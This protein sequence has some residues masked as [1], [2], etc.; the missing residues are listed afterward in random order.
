MKISFKN[1]VFFAVFLIYFIFSAIIFIITYDYNYQ[2]NRKNFMGK[3]GYSTES[4]EDMIEEEKQILIRAARTISSEETMYHALKNGIYVSNSWNLDSKNSKIEIDIKEINRFYFIKLANSVRNRL[5]GTGRGSEEKGIELFN[6]KLELVGVS[7]EFNNKFLDSGN[8]KYLKDAIKAESINGIEI[9]AIQEKNGEYFLKGIAPVGKNSRYFTEKPYGVAVVGEELGGVIA[10]KMKSRINSEIVIIKDGEL[11]L[12]TIFADGIRLKNIKIITNNKIDDGKY[13][14][15]L[16][17]G[18]KYGANF[19]ELRDYQNR[20]IGYIGAAENLVFLDKINRTAISNYLKLQAVTTLVLFIILYFAI[21][22]LFKP[23]REMM[24]SINLIGEGNYEARVVEKGGKEIVEL[25]KSVNLMACEIERRES[26]LKKFNF[27]MEQKVNQR[28]KELVEKNA[29]LYELLNKLKK[30]NSKNEEE[31]EFARRIHEQIVKFDFEKIDSYDIKI[32]NWSIN[33]IGG[34]F[35]E[36][37]KLRNG[38]TGIFFADI[39]GHGVAAALMISAVKI[40]VNLYFVEINKPSEALYFL[41]DMLIRDMIPGVTISAV[42]MVINEK[43]NNLEIAQAAQEYSYYISEN[44]VEKIPGKG[45]ILGVI[46][47]EEIEENEKISYKD[48]VYKLKPGDKIFVYT[49]GLVE[50]ENLNRDNLQEIILKGASTNINGLNEI[51]EKEISDKVGNNKR[52]D[53][54]YMIIEKSC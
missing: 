20:V 52:D 44:S 40:I 46:E 8:E 3:N 45:I 21:G 16:I 23:L 39:A 28:T 51:I 36:I 2:T 12:S 34:D 48:I 24:S 49:D 1:I 22:R 42:Y 29:E 47:S 18:I 13:A 30:I 27:E 41:N 31:L 17:N 33:G 25:A 26:S 10:E 15:F 11:K 38:N 32:K 6:S 9:A 19:K 4:I 50:N 43:E 54:T 35:V 5:F 37:V 7:D 53:L 14:E